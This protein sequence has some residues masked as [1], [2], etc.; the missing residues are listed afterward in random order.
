M[1]TSER[2]EERRRRHG[3]DL[4]ALGASVTTTGTDEDGRIAV[5]VDAAGDVIGVEVAKDDPTIR[6]SE[7]LA[8]TVRAA[9]VRAEG[10]RSLRSAEESGLADR[11]EPASAVG[12]HPPRH[13]TILPFDQAEARAYAYWHPDEDAITSRTSRTSDNGYVTVSYSSAGVPDRVEADPDWLAST[14]PA[15]LTK[16]LKETLIR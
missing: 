7:G 6:S 4:Y 14:T 15:Y 9:L 2:L 8:Q 12:H 10:A 13:A 5:T 1:G 16:A 11:L 3:S